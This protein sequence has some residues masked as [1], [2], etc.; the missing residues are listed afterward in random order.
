MRRSGC[1]TGS[2]RRPFF[3][4]STDPDAA[5]RDGWRVRLWIFCST[6]R[7]ASSSPA[8]C[9]SR[10]PARVLVPDRPGAR[11]HPPRPD[12]TQ[13]LVIGWVFGTLVSMIGMTAG[14]PPSSTS[15]PGPRCVRVRADADRALGRFPGGSAGVGAPHAV[16]VTRRS[17]RAISCWPRWSPGARACRP[18]G[19][20]TPRPPSRERGAA[21][22]RALWAT[23]RPSDDRGRRLLSRHALPRADVPG[24]R[25]RDRR[26]PLRSDAVPGT[27]GIGASRSTRSR[28]G[29][30]C[31][32]STMA[33]AVALK[34]TPSQ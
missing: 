21:G 9:A 7:S 32:S 5:Y 2:C 15:R 24:V 26:D 22:C 30:S 33:A 8:R 13:K 3:L 29:A 18:R 20:S 1:F 16:R 6:R 23:R 28:A 4:I 12:V 25:R 10:R 17:A 11:R 27:N 34:L 19:P 14:G 31:G